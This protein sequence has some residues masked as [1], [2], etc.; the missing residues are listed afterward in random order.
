VSED[1]THHLG[2]LHDLGASS[3][4]ETFDD[5]LQPVKNKTFQN[6]FLPA[7]RIAWFI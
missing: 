5:M 3:T 6:N 4:K 7:H 1:K 2:R